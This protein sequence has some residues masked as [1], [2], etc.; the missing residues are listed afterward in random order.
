V[1]KCVFPLLAS[2]LALSGC[3]ST[4]G[5]K[6]DISS[7]TFEVGN[8]KKG[9][10]ANTLGLPADISRSGAL[11]R[12]YWAYR[13]KPELT[14]V[15]YAL[16]SGGGST[17]THHFSTGEDGTYDF[18]DAAVVYVFDNTG[19]LVDVRRFDEKK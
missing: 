11:G 13:D 6:T 3:A 1:N 5:N 14:G 8:T 9:T 4:I 16:P 10:V 19:T 7:V 2:L 15:M 18:E 17:T 12:E